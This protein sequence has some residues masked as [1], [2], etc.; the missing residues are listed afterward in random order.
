V[1]NQ[2]FGTR[3]IFTFIAVVMSFFA[4]S[5]LGH[6]DDELNFHQAKRVNAESRQELRLTPAQNKGLKRLA[7]ELAELIAGS[8]A[9]A[10]QE[11]ST[12]SA[13]AGLILL[14]ENNLISQRIFQTM[15]QDLDRA[16]EQNLSNRQATFL[17]SLDW[18]RLHILTTIT[19]FFGVAFVLSLG[20]T[21]LDPI[22]VKAINSM[23]ALG[24]VG[25]AGSL[26]SRIV[27]HK[28]T[29]AKEVEEGV[30]IAFLLNELKKRGISKAENVAKDIY[31]EALLLGVPHQFLADG[32]SFVS[33]LELNQEKL[34]DYIEFVKKQGHEDISIHIDSL[35]LAL[36]KLNIIISR[37]R[38]RLGEDPL[39]SKYEDCV[40]DYL[41]IK[42]EFLERTS[43][44][45]F[46]VKP[47]T[48]ILDVEVNSLTEKKSIEIFRRKIIDQFQEMYPEFYAAL[49]TLFTEDPWAQA[50]FKINVNI[51]STDASKSIEIK[52]SS[53][54]G[55]NPK[56]VVLKYNEPNWPEDFD[57]AQFVEKQNAYTVLVE[58]IYE[59]AIE[60]YGEYDEAEFVEDEFP[61]EESLNLTA[62]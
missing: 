60:S 50:L 58:G 30:L 5:M 9:N 62:L 12:T 38:E 27:K 22:V 39:Q 29:Q 16:G 24:L 2:S 34:Q 6:A 36:Q 47:A 3:K 56:E 8:D 7:A 26:G 28:K 14:T 61:C 45:R 20:K 10:L 40:V 35:E 54:L 57:I 23:F 55:P 21:T 11:Q 13:L 53:R 49:L 44:S 18:K 31:I 51:V 48:A 25:I 32:L 19:T 17:D 33:Y 59:S 46:F 43:G 4:I 37:L 41:K 15:V 52:I 1:N 42:K